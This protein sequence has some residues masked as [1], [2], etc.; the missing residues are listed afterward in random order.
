MAAVCRPVGRLAVSESGDVG[1]ATD[2]SLGLVGRGLIGLRTHCRSCRCRMITLLGYSDAA[3]LGCYFGH[4][5]SASYSQCKATATGFPW[6]CSIPAYLLALAVRHGHELGPKLE[7]AESTT[8]KLGEGR[9]SLLTTVLHDRAPHTAQSA[10][11]W[12][13]TPPEPGTTP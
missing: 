3:I 4:S 1:A 10:R 2:L 13:G 12:L 7:L 9:G 8:S 6:P 11:V 5:P